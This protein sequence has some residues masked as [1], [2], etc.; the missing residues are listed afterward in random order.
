MRK[1]RPHVHLRKL[2]TFINFQGHQTAQD[3]GRN[4][5]NQI[6]QGQFTDRSHHHTDG[7]VNIAAADIFGNQH[8]QRQCRANRNRIPRGQY[9]KDKKA[10]AQKFS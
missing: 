3:L 5:G 6:V 1:T 10:C 7:G 2:N 4:I 8:H 9:Y